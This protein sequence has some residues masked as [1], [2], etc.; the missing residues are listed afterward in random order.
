MNGATVQE[1]LEGFLNSDEYTAMGK[2][3]SDTILDF[4][5]GLLGREAETEG[6]NH[7]I[8]QYRKG[9]SLS[10][11]GTH[12][13]LDSDEFLSRDFWLNLLDAKTAISNVTEKTIKPE[14]TPVDMS[15][16]IDML[17]EKSAAA[18]GISVEE[19]KPVPQDL[20]SI[21]NL[22]NAP[23][24]NLSTLPQ[25][26]NITNMG[27]TVGEVHNTITFAIDRVLDYNDLVTQMQKDGKFEKMIED[28]TIG[29][30]AGRSSINKN[31]YK[32]G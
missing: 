17:R 20:S 26:S 19:L 23:Q 32:W 13:F 15:E 31:R 30:L 29:K 25:T 21:F 12:G 8:E 22:K 11:I 4:Y 3:A 14:F 9:M 24:L 7:W 28:M 1:M 16:F 6:Y 18:K 2:S 10:E 27:N 5:R